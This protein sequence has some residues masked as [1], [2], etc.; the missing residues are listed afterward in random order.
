M[1][2]RIKLALFNLLT[3]LVFAVLF[4]I[5]MP[6]IIERI[7]LRQVDNNLIE[8]REKVISLISET[9]IEPFII[10][11]TANAFGSY[12][13]LKE[14]FISLEKIDTEEDLNYI[15]VTPRLIEGEEI[16]YRVLN[17]SFSV[18]GQK[19]LLEVGKSIQSIVET[20]KDIRN[21]MLAFLILIILFTFIADYQY[22]RVILNP[23]EKIKNKLKLIS[24]PALFDM[25]PV[26]TNTSD[27]VALDNTLCELMDNINKLFRKEKDITVNI[28]HE[29]LT[30]VS[31]LRSKLENILLK[32]NL[33]H[34]IEA[35]IE[36]S[37]KT[38]HRLQS[39]VNSLLMIA[40]IESHQ[41][42]REDSVSV[43]EVLEEVADEIEPLSEDA[44]IILKKELIDDLRIEKANRSLIFSMFFNIVNNSVRNTPSGGLVIIESR[45]LN[46]Y[47]TVGISDTGKGLTE[48]QKESLFSRFRM[49]NKESGDGTGIG[50]AIAKTIA[51]FH[52]IDVSVKSDQGKGTTFTF[53]FTDHSS[54]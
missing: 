25:T 34:D 27:F 9:G 30:P 32:E 14:E 13:I 33:D 1:R 28:S 4:I 7:N 49:R 42:L 5:L 29:L 44:G 16:V 22:T 23:L 43:S 2:L 40:K 39:L 6:F 38:L 35:R 47:F 50:L 19:Y 26:R 17:Y 51:D 12:N 36:E 24:D 21:V 37:L 52:G 3:K 54:F 41:Y 31:V 18:D 10:S 8:K 11:D 53:L 45:Y 20:G 15:D 46:K 48:E